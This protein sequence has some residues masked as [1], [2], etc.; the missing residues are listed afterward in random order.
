[1]KNKKIIVLV[2]SINPVKIKAVK[3]VFKKIFK[4]VEVKGRKSASGVN[5]QP[6]S[7]EEA[8]KGALN[9]AKN[10]SKKGEVFDYLVGIEGGIQK[11]SFGWVTG[12]AIVIINQ[13]NEIG[14]GFSPQLLL[15][16][17]IIKRIKKGNEL[18]QVLENISG[19]KDIKQK[20]GAFGY[21]TDNLLTREKAYEAGV[22]FALARFLKKEMYAC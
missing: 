2:G 16:S 6:I 22:I 17:R 15:G 21:F 10:L 8:Y 9:R 4:K 7:F 5:P 12:G 3:N 20:Q 18:G 11:Y 1:M 13:K 14:V 19:I